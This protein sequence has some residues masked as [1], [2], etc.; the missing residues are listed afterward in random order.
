[1][2]W[3]G[4]AWHG[5]GYEVAVVDA[6]GSTAAPQARFGGRQV[7]ALIAHLRD[8]AARSADDL[9]AVIDSSTGTI[10]GHVLAAGFAVYR[11]DPP[12]LP[13]PP[14]L[15]SVPAPDLARCA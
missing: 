15:G 13:Q 1:M 10:D 7:P 3:A 9:A 12:L 8:A 11:A 4:V 5:D 6:A 14:S 2:W